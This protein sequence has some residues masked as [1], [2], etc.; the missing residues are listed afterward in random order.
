[1][2]LTNDNATLLV[3]QGSVRA[4]LQ[5]LLLS[6]LKTSTY[7]ARCWQRCSL[8]LR[9]KMDGLAVMIVKDL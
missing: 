1:M 7:Q 5:L 4:G 6:N 9:S 8:F 2:Y 3:L